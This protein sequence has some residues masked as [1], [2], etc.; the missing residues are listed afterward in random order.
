MEMASNMTKNKTAKSPSLTKA[1]S[2][3]GNVLVIGGSGVGKSTLINAVV[4]DEVAPTSW[5]RAGTEELKIYGEPPMPFRLIDTM[6]FEVSLRRQHK[7]ENAIKKWSRDCAK[8]GKEDT[9]INVI[10]FCVDGTSARLFDETIARLN[11][12]TSIWKSV[13]VIAV[14]TKSYSEY[15]RE[16]NVEM[17]RGAFESQGD[18][19]ALDVILRRPDY[20]QRLR[21]IVPVVAQAWKQS[22]GNIVAPYGIDDLIELTNELMPEG[23]E[24]AKKDLSDYI[25]LRRRALSQGVIAPSVVAG[26]VVGA[27]PLPIADALVLGPVEAAEINAIARI[28]GIAGKKE[29]AALTD[30][31]IDVGTVSVAAKG[32]LGVLKAVPGVSVAAEVLNATVAASFV[33]AL[34]EGCVYVFEQ[35]CAGK[36]DVTDLEAIRRYFEGILQSQDFLNRVT[37]ALK[38]MRNG[39]DAASI[40]KAVGILFAQG[41]GQAAG[42]AGERG[43]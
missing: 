2:P 1:A 28:Y 40:A 16:R 19:G 5:G 42:G 31:I 20:T 22:E 17:V 36:M 32:A 4:G 35:V 3:L 30:T 10:W 27:L 26:A 6:G 15:E 13:P 9:Q 24:R 7:A 18:R 11:E 41:A 37:Q 43:W 38:S 25:M 33:A 29:F 12:A 23:L 14:I 34:G 39:M 21:G 8:E